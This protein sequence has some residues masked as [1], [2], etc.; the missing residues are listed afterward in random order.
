VRFHLSLSNVH[1][2]NKSISGHIFVLLANPGQ[3][4]PQV[5][6]YPEVELENGTPSD[7]RK[8]TQFQISYGK[9]VRGEVKGLENAREYTQ[10]WVYVYS[11][12]GTL[13]LRKLLKAD[14][15]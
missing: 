4:P 13:L 9:T 8:G 3:D 1:P 7:W 12:D 11:Q 15:A 10:A 6:P 14:H 2:D 5:A